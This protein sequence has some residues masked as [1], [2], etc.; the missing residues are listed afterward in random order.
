MNWNRVLLAGLYGALAGLVMEACKWWWRR[1]K[2]DRL[3]AREIGGDKSEDQASE[4]ASPKVPSRLL[5]NKE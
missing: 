4:E 1:K 5:K 3:P 2:Q